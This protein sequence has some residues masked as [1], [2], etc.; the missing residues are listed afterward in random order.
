M[1]PYTLLWSRKPRPSR[2]ARYGV[3][4]VQPDRRPGPRRIDHLAVPGVDTDVVDGGVSARRVAEEDQVSW[5]QRAAPPAGGDALARLAC[6]AAV[7]GS[8]I[9]ARANAYW[10]RPEQSKPLIPAPDLP[11]G[12][13]Q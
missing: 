1:R 2:E 9:P 8:A 12:E 10:V 7:R 5:T 3:H 6:A 13:Q 4:G 11:L